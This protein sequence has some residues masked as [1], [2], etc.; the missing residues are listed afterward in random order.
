MAI[1]EYAKHL[2]I[3]SP[4][5]PTIVRLSRALGR[6]T[7]RRHPE[8]AHILDEGDF[9]ERGFRSLLRCDS[10]CIDVGAHLGSQLSVM[11]R[12]APLGRH[13]AFEPVPYKARWL[14][15][16]FP[17]V[18]VKEMALSARRGQVT[19]FVNSTRSG[20]SSLRPHADVGDQLQEITVEQGRLDDVVG[21]KRRF[22][23]IKI[24]V[25][26]GELRVL[27]GASGLIDCWRPTILLESTESGLAA[28]S[29][30]ADDLYDRIVGQHDYR[31]YPPRAFLEGRPALTR[32]EF[33]AAHVYPFQAFNFFAVP[34]ARAPRGA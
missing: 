30:T 18:E 23:F 10:S 7:R 24:D 4:I 22:D 2:V 8:I 5:E 1:S 29:V 12:L 13:I 14:R 15:R 25:E 11:M 9:V 33:A 6:L 17:E 32:A 26:G 16:K 19:F 31:L 28:A 34:A 27:E 20:Y 21:T 3:R